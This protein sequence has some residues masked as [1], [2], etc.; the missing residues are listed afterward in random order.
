MKKDEQMEE[1]N[2]I[3]LVMEE[4]SEEITQ[5]DVN[6]IVCACVDRWCEIA[7]EVL[8]RQEKKE[9]NKTNKLWFDEECKKLRDEYMGKRKQMMECEESV[10]EDKI[11]E[12]R[13][14]QR[15]YKRLTKK[16]EWGV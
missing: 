13:E 3:L 5:C 9:G 2:E 8:G 7:N 4:H 16:K 11:K 10:K 6:S 15:G 14:K 12:M 1:L